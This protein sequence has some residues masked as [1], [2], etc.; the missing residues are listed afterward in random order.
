MTRYLQT[1][2]L[3]APQIPQRPSPNLGIVVVIP[4]YDERWLLRSLLSLKGCDRPFCDVEVIVVVNSSEKENEEVKKRNYESVEQT[5]NWINKN[6]QSGIKF[7]VLHFPDLL[8]KQAGVGLARKI[9]M[10]EACWRFEKMGNQKGIIACFDADSR[11]D[12]NYFLAL[13]SHFRQ[14][15]DTQACSIYFEHPLSGADFDKEVYDAIIQYELHLRYYTNAQKYASFPF[16]CETIGSSMAVR[17]DAYQQQGGMNKRKAGEDFYFIHK[18]TPLGNFTELNKTRVIPS[19]RPSHRVPFGTGKAVDEMLKNKKELKTYSLESF[20]DLKLFLKKVPS[21]FEMKALDV[22]QMLEL[23][24]S[25]VSSFLKTIDFLEKWKEIKRNTTNSNNFTSRFFRWFNA[26]QVMKFVHFSR[27]HFYP[28]I[29]V[30][31]AAILL[32]EKLK[33]EGADK[34]KDL[35]LAYREMDRKE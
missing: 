25:P 3:Y 15:P 9:G 17:C 11:C 5:Q 10:D 26:F 4:S 23:L 18:F 31:E 13:A 7:H 19:P 33:I 22:Q 32:L 6:R 29:P 12:P 24:P 8:P 30:E 1:R 14:Y 16:A 34:A 21:L 2:T 35:L 27:D 20:E 28:D